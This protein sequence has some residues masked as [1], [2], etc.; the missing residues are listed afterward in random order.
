[1]KCWEFSSLCEDVLG[2]CGPDLALCNH[3][4]VGMQDFSPPEDRSRKGLRP[5]TCF[6]LIRAEKRAWKVVLLCHGLTFR[7]VSVVRC[8]IM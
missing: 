4:A 6:S 1:M 7:A 2:A 8:I 5:K 3:P